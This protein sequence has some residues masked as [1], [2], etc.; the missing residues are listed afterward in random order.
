MTAE[1][2]SR[3]SPALLAA[4]LA[5][6][7]LLSAGFLALGVW[8]VHRLAWKEALIARVDALL[9]AD[10]VPA[11]GPAQWPALRRETDEYRRLAVHGRFDFSREVLVR[12]STEI[13]PGFWVLT[14]MRTDAGPWVLVNRGFVPPEMRG[15]VPHGDAEQQVVGLLRFSEPK[16]GPLQAN[17]P[18]EGRWYS[19][20]VAAIAADR[21]LAGE[22]APYFVDR[23]AVAPSDRDAW[24]RP[25]LTVVN[26]PNNHLV[27]ALTWFALALGVAAGAG[28]LV[29]DERRLRRAA[30][31]PSRAA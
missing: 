22:V 31:A 17:V 18:A 2:R 26:F 11:P 23:Q 3:R 24:P 1:A 29:V 19:R 7:L 14:P 6:L 20:D 9:R 15:H 12:A 25:G 28:F 10:P 16:G 30:G 4:A 5:L 21:G 27:Y 13:G 8:Q